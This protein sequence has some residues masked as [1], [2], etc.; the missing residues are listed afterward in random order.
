M[1]V[2]DKVISTVALSTLDLFHLFFECGRMALKYESEFES[3]KKP[4]RD[5]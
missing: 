3:D 2:Q 5:G 4:G 1:A